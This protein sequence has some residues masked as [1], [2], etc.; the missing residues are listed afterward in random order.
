MNQPS[1][2]EASKLTSK[3]ILPG[4]GVCVSKQ[5]Y[6]KQKSYWPIIDTFAQIWLCQGFALNLTQNEKAMLK[7]KKKGK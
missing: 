6:Y 4:K 1:K 7:K 5:S 3:R 2:T